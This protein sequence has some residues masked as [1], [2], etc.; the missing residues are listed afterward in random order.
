MA[1]T[2]G[3]RY[4]TFFQKRKFRTTAQ[5]DPARHLMGALV[6][7]RCC[8]PRGKCLYSSGPISPIWIRIILISPWIST[9]WRPTW[10]IWHNDPQ[11][12][13]FSLKSSEEWRKKNQFS[14][15]L[16]ASRTLPVLQFGT[17]WGSCRPHRPVTSGW[18]WPSAACSRSCGPPPAQDGLWG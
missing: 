13:T 11:W 14:K 18:G 1:G 9:W 8:K 4:R 10:K 12:E 3:I 5:W 6:L 16:P 15:I 7:I 17:R 2:A